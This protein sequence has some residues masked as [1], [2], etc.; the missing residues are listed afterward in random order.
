MRSCAVR[1][2]PSVFITVRGDV[3]AT[4]RRAN[5]AGIVKAKPGKAARP[6]SLRTALQRW[7]QA[8]SKAPARNCR[9]AMIHSVEAGCGP[10]L[11]IRN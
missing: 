3:P 1:G 6:A 8:Y 7:W 9:Q 10:Y 5:V 2:G 11:Y 4:I